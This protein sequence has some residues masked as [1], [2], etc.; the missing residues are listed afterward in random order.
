MTL[1]K[2]VKKA[3]KA[4]LNALRDDEAIYSPTPLS[5]PLHC[6]PSLVTLDKPVPTIELTADPTT[7]ALTT[8]A[9]MT[10][11]TIE[12]TTELTTEPT[13]K[14]TRPTTELSPEPTTRL[15]TEPVNDTKEKA[16][17]LK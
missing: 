3:P 7:D 1:A 10:E 15:G 11:P 13:T 4:T 2:R 6:L 12:L 5:L 9:L 17:I 14:P 8:D 16:T